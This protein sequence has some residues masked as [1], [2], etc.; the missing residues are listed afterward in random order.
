[1]VTSAQ[2]IGFKNFLFAE[3]LNLFEF[4]LFLTYLEVRKSPLNFFFLRMRGL[5]KDG[6][7]L[8][9]NPQDP[10]VETKITVIYQNLELRI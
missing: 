5:F 7:T 6:N 8:E 1:M 9:K 4:Q 10:G 3:L 2:K